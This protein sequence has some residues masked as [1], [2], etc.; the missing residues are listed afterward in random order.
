MSAAGSLSRCVG[1]FLVGWIYND[2]GT[3]WTFACSIITSLL[4]LAL[5]LL[6]Y[7]RLV[8]FQDR[9]TE[10]DGEE[11]EIEITKL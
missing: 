7:K 6:S 4:A 9:D 2:Y 11:L 10:E 3:Y 5:I 8:P 1:P